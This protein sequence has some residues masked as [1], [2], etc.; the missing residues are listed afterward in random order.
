MGE[1]SIF[2]GELAGMGGES[3]AEGSEPV[4]AGIAFQ[5]SFE[6]DQHGG[7]ADIAVVAERH[8]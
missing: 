5:C 4:G 2:A 7:T 6:G 8:D 1:W 3:G